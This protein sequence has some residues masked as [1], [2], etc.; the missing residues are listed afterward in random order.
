MQDG[1]FFFLF[2]SSAWSV[3]RQARAEEELS[4]GGE[5]WCACR[6]SLHG[7]GCLAL[8]TPLVLPLPILYITVAAPRDGGEVSVHPLRWELSLLNTDRRVFRSEDS[9]QQTQC[10]VIRVCS[11]KPGT[12]CAHTY[13]NR[14]VQHNVWTEYRAQKCILQRF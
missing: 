6:Q 7:N 8:V 13:G 1:I 10:W 5:R 2:S 12:S 3:I 4:G 9:E 14:Q 11:G